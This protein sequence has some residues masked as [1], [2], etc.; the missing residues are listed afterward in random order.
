MMEEAIAGLFLVM[1]SLAT[2]AN[3][4]ARY[5]FNAP[6]TWAEEFS[7]YAFIWLVF[8]G[9][10]AC[11]KRYRH[12][13][14]DVLVKLLPPPLQRV[15]RLLADSATVVLMG[16]LVYYGGLLTLSATHPTSTLMVPTYVVYAAVPLSALFIL[17]YA[18]RDLWRSVR[19]LLPTA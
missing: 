9:A 19:D 10:A 2:A 11:S 3:V 5:L 1:M 14:I 8:M 17:A 13:C 15:S 12:I 4:V 7:R 18:L 6:I 16:I